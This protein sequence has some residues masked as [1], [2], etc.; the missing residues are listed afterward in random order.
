MQVNYA[1]MEELINKLFDRS[2]QFADANYHLSDMLS[3]VHDGGLDGKAGKRLLDSL[4][5]LQTKLNSAGNLFD[6]L[7]KEVNKATEEMRER[8]NAAKF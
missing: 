8:D 2:L 6:S 4:H 7:A 5:A 1:V 3:M